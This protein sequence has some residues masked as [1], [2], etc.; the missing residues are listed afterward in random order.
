VRSLTLMANQQ[1]KA[2]VS[3]DRW[4]PISQ[5]HQPGERAQ[6]CDAPVAQ[7]L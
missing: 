6:Q 4:K 2:P 5:K 1:E 7:G 3:G